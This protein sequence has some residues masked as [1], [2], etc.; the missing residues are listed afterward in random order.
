MLSGLGLRLVPELGLGLRLVP[1]LGLGLGLGLGLVSGLELGFG[2]G[3]CICTPIDMYIHNLVQKEIT[4]R[5][6][7]EFSVLAPIHSLRNC[8]LSR[9][10]LLRLVDSMEGVY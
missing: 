7:T 4:D 9:Y 1:E 5:Q 10:S 2:L 3:L 8:D 6:S